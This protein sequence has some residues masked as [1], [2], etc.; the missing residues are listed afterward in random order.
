MDRLE[1]ENLF[2]QDAV[3]SPTA[4]GVERERFNLFGGNQIPD[5]LRFTGPTAGQIRDAIGG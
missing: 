5:M 1:P 3:S 4:A 2:E